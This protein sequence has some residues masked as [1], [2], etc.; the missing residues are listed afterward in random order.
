VVP[1][2]V[3]QSMKSAILSRLNEAMLEIIKICISGIFEQ[4]G[5][6][7]SSIIPNNNSISLFDK[8]IDANAVL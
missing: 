4:E 2:I 7:R 8:K 1:M 5:F 6:N 3:A